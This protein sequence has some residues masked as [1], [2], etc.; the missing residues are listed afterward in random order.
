MYYEARGEG[1]K[2]QQA[3]AHVSL[4]RARKAQK[5]L[6]WVLKQ[7]GQYSFMGASKIVPKAPKAFF[8]RAANMISEDYKGLRK[9]FTKG[10]MF[11]FHKDHHSWLTEKLV[12]VKIVGNH[13]FMKLRE[14]S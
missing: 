2:G 6:C 9:D 5:S 13:K 4:N 11:F 3:V 10:A 14:K 12:H 8:N 1:I 7:P